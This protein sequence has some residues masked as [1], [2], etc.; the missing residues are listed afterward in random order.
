MTVRPVV[1]AF[2]VCAPLMAQ[3]GPA[4]CDQSHRGAMTT[5]LGGSGRPDL[6]K[7]CLKDGIGRFSWGNASQ[8]NP[9][10]FAN[11][12]MVNGCPIFPDNNVWSSK[13]DGLPLAG[14]SAVIIKTYSL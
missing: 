4:V 3:A 2:V 13:V 1:L 11:V 12:R 8:Q 14:D 6:L 10:T 5:E 9:N 7:V